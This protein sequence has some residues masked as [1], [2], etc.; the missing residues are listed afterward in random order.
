[1]KAHFTTH[2]REAFG[3]ENV[4]V[5][6]LPPHSS[7]LYQILDLCFFGGMKKEHKQSRTGRALSS[8]DEKLTQKIER[9]VRAWHGACFIET[10]LA[11]WRSAGFLY[12][13]D[14][15]IIQR[16]RV[17]PTLILSKLTQ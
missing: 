4:I 8:L 17:N 9:V 1:L 15:G 13:W 6:P 2:V 10:V 11:A 5:I 14:G 3:Q 7:H 16:I 12:E